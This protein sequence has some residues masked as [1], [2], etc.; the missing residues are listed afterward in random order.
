ML[1]QQCSYINA[2]ALLICLFVCLVI[3]DSP[4]LCNSPN[5]SRTSSVDQAGFKITEILLTLLLSAGLKVCTP[6]PGATAFLYKKK[7]TSLR[8][9]ESLAEVKQ[10][11]YQIQKRLM[12]GE[13]DQLLGIAL[14]MEKGNRC[15]LSLAN[16]E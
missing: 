3:Q 5:Y 8:P 11:C 10:M 1:L 4:S 13:P 12:D 2:T 9:G 6:L 7:I 16:K 15:I 14:D